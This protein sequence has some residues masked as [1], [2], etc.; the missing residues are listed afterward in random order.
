LRVIASY[1]LRIQEAVLTGESVPVDKST[2]PVDQDASLGDRRSMAFSGAL[3]AAG[4]GRGIVVATGTETEIGR[5]SGMLE[6]VE[7]TTTP[8]LR[9]ME[10]FA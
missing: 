7:T 5:I 2:T 9:Q 8:L 4:A 6:T 3:V 10:G 1:G